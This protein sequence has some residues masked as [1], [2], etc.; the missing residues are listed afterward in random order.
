MI[1]TAEGDESPEGENVVVAAG[2]H[3]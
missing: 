3:R 1:P 2:E